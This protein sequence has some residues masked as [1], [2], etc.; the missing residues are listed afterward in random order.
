MLFCDFRAVQDKSNQKGIWFPP[1]KF[2]ALSGVQ[3]CD[4][5][6]AAWCRGH[7]RAAPL[8]MSNCIICRQQAQADAGWAKLHEGSQPKRKSYDGKRY[9]EKR[10]VS[11][12][13]SER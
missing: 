6:L 12:A 11:T 1:R 7:D 13:V 3:V 5:V 9:G 2:F 8:T 4:G 10:R